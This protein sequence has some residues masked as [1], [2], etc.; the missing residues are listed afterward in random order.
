MRRL[1]VFMRHLAHHLAPAGNDRRISA[2]RSIWRRRSICSIKQ[3]ATRTI[4]AFTSSSA[5][6]NVEPFVMTSLRADWIQDAPGGQFDMENA[7]YRPK[8]R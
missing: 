2:P 7:R 4:L 8:S 6:L 1:H 3:R 5:D